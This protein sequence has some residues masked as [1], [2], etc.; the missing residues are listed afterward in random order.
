M[1]LPRKTI[2][3]DLKV[4]THIITSITAGPIILLT[5]LEIMYVST[6]RTA[7]ILYLLTNSF[8]SCRKCNCFVFSIFNLVWLIFCFWNIKQFTQ[9]SFLLEDIQKKFKTSIV[10]V[11]YRN[12]LCILNLISTYLWYMF[13]LRFEKFWHHPSDMSVIFLFIWSYVTCFVF[14]FRWSMFEPK[15]IMY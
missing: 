12:V 11:I 14:V 10:C 9:P 1:M 6:F 2:T 5:I 7:I 15:V 8:Y 13:L 4:S 3:A